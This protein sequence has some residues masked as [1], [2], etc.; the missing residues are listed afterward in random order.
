VILEYDIR[1]PFSSGDSYYDDIQK[2]RSSTMVSI[3]TSQSQQVRSKSGI[4]IL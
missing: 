4:Q 1:D 2:A 3:F